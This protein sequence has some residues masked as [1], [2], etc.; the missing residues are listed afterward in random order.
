M[1]VQNIARMMQ[2][3]LEQ[4][5]IN[6]YVSQGCHR[7]RSRRVPALRCMSTQSRR[8]PQQ[9]A[10]LALQQQSSAETVLFPQPNP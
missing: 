5:H 9:A 3:A 8:W 2:G 1:Y 7:G 10:R 4:R 6:T